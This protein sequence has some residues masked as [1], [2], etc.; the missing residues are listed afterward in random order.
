MKWGIEAMEIY[1]PKTFVDQTDL[2]MSYQIQ[3]SIMECLKGNTP[4]G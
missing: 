2:G 4:R 1:F 3:K